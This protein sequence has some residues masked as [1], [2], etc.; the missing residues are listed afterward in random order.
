M[1]LVAAVLAAGS[2]WLAASRLGVTTD[3]ST[4]FDARLPWKQRE[5]ELSRQFPQFDQLLVA[6]VDADGPEQAD[7]TASGLAAALSADPA[8]FRSIRRPDALPF[9]AKDG[10]LLLDRARL[11]AMLDQIVDAQ[12]FLGQLAADPSL[13]G[14]F[15]ALSLVGMGVE[16]GQAALGPFTPALQAFHAAL[17]GA[18][19][20]EAK[21]LSW[22][23]LLAGAAAGLGGPYRLVLAQPVLEFGA[24][25][26]GAAAT[27]SLRH[28]AGQLEFVRAGQARVRVTGSVALADEE[29]ATVA[30][31]VAAGL[32]GTLA[33]VLLWLALAVRTWRLVVPILATLLLGLVFTTAFAA[34]TSS[35]LN[36]ISVAF[37]ILFVGIAVDFAI[38]FGVRFREARQNLAGTAAALRAAAERAGGQILVAAA[39]TAAGFL[40]FVPTAFRGVAE[41]GLVAGVG[42]LIAFA[43]TLTVLPAGITL[44]RADRGAEP[45]FGW[46]SPLD[47]FIAWARWPLL[48]GFVALGGCGLAALPHLVFDSNPLHTKDPSTEAMRTLADLAAL[49]LT[50]PYTID[51]LAAGPAAAAEIVA[52]ASAL[53]GV[54]QVL[55]LASFVPTEQPEKL[56]LIADAGSLL[57]P[58]LAPRTPAAP[59]TASDLRL[60]ARMALSQLDRALPRL[61]PD[62]PLVAIAADTRALAEAQDDTL[63]AAN[64]ALT[65]FLPD[66]IERLRTSLMAEPVSLAA[67]PPELARDWVLPDGR[68]R[69]QISAR[70]GAGDPAAMG[71]FVDQVRQAIPDIGGPAVTIE[72][73]EATI[74]RAFEQAAAGAVAAIMVIL[75]ATLRRPLDVALVLTPLLLSALLTALV[76]VLLPLP[77]NFANVIALPLLLGVGVSFNI[78]FVMN[79]RAGLPPRLASATARGVA[80]SALTTGTA[81]GALALSHHPGTASMGTLLLL[82]LGCTLFVS[83]VFVPVTLVILSSPL[84]SINRT[85]G[86]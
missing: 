60:A 52:K 25:Q 49:P 30:Q 8:H 42:M 50:D 54:G 26:P 15:A 38:Q 6:V 27:A 17:N 14:L 71:R 62:N 61:P 1:L 43:C 78:Y 2:V 23:S 24:L 5:A 45:G 12:P 76:A 85:P 80:F 82:S 39:A 16:R 48:A 40:A 34:L 79:W 81:F 3:L 63:L 65:R 4:L 28:T 20:G 37:A 72:A 51:V 22:Q 18:A 41:L 57:A 7:A 67:L 53:P 83:L 47:R 66:Q 19:N 56:V 29:F 73:T 35:P 58:T 36:L 31:G 74:I 59:V 75:L 9:F 64:A 68:M 44:C 33:F 84:T 70:G 55:S 86:P 21:P 46:A 11:S 32:G 77:L 13:R 69:V 10:L